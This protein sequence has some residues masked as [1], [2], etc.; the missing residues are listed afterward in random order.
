V[1]EAMAN[2]KTAGKYEPGG[3]REAL[4]EAYGRWKEELSLAL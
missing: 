3:E 4:E 2:V 1:E